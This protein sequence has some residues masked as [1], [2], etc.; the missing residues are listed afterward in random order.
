MPQHGLET[1]LREV[2]RHREGILDD[3][4]DRMVKDSV[5]LDLEGHFT[6]DEFFNRISIPLGSDFNMESKKIFKLLKKREN[7]SST[8]ISSFVSIPHIILEGSEVLQMMIVRCRDGVSFSDLEKSV[9][10]IFLIVGNEGE[11]VLHLRLL[12]SIATLVQEK[13]FQNKWL[14][15]KDTNHLRDMI[16]LSSRKRF[17]KS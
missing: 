6:L 17:P 13:G 14:E 9:K 15:A 7:E 1:E 5:I 2:L 3:K 11:R 4:F 8:A 10:A 12:A 16:L